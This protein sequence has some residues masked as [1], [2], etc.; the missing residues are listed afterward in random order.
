MNYPLRGFYICMCF[1]SSSAFAK[2]HEIVN[3][4]LQ[5]STE[6]SRTLLFVYF[7]RTVLKK[8]SLL[9]ETIAFL[10]RI[11][12]LDLKFLTWIFASIFVRE[13]LKPLKFHDVMFID[14]MISLSYLFLSL[15]IIFV[16]YIF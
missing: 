12:I 7:F 2:I 9:Y 3:Y 11:S 1:P 10:C 4:L 15:N 8:L 14:P 6:K 5:M 13:E 16:V